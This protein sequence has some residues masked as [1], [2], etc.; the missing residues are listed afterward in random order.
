MG[1]ELGKKLE[2]ELGARVLFVKCNVVDEKSVTA[3]LQAGLAKFGGKLHGVVNCGEY[4]LMILCA[5][6]MLVTST[7]L[8]FH[9]LQLALETLAAF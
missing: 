9:V 4:L 5:L 6:Y 2:A 3:A 1:E 7:E 8:F